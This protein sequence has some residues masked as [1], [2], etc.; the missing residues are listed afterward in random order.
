MINL[1]HGTWLG[2]V[3]LVN[4]PSLGAG[5]QDT[6]DATFSQVVA[7]P[8][9]IV[10]FWS[11]G[12]PACMTFKPIFEAFAAQNPDILFAAVNTDQHVQNAGT[13][14]V[15][16]LPTVVFFVNGKEV[17]RMVGGTDQAGFM[18]EIAQAFSGTVPT[19]GPQ[20]VIVRAPSSGVPVAGLVLGGLALAG[21][22]YLI[23]K[24]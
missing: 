21:A 18:G 23:F 2:Q 5:V 17:H 14:Q 24:K 20:S 1:K 22:A 16:G 12:C 6:T 4:R 7:A 19:G 9:A 13:Y 8:K 3:P 11:P 10:E 15:S